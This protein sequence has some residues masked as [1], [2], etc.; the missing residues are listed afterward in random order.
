[1]VGAGMLFSL[2][3]FAER[4]KGKSTAVCTD[5]P[6]HWDKP[7]KESVSVSFSGLQ[8]GNKDTNS[9]QIHPLPC[10]Q[11]PLS[12]EDIGLDLTSICKGKATVSPYLPNVGLYVPRNQVILLT[13]YLTCNIMHRPTFHS[14]YTEYGIKNEP[15]A[16]V[17][18]KEYFTTHHKSVSVKD[19][20]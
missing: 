19:C 20:V 8:M 11:F 10:T 18:F 3:S 14:V 13:I 2:Q 5:V 1:M 15:I 16:K 9:C 7:R 4:H 12:T 17:I 6:C